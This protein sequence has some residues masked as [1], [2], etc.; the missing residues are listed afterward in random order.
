[1]KE[2]N[3]GDLTLRSTTHPPHQRNAKPTMVLAGFSSNMGSK[4]ENHGKI[5]DPVAVTW[6]ISLL[7]AICP[8]SCCPFFLMLLTDYHLG[9]SYMLMSVQKSKYI[10][11]FL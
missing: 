8:G 3:S 7:D 2:A 9:I 4:S 5:I 1:M 11:Y 10:H 6:K